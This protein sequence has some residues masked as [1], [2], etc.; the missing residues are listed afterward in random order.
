LLEEACVQGEGLKQ[1]PSKF[2]SDAIIEVM[3]EN[4]R[5]YP[6]IKSQYIGTEEGVMTV[7][8]RRK[9]CPTSYDPQFR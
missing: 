9:T 5:K 7:Y 6:T 3:K 4:L 8:P 2:I 1:N